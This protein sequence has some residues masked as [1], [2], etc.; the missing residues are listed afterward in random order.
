M[1]SVQTLDGTFSNNFCMT[2]AKI[3]PLISVL[4]GVALQ[5][6][7]TSSASS[8]SSPSSDG[9]GRQGLDVGE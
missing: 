5:D 2:R 6:E 1:F 3:N 7:A 9:E 8:T 4:T